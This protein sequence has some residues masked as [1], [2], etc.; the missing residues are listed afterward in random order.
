VERRDLVKGYEFPKNRY[1]L[2]NDEDFDSVKVE[3]SSVM[4]IDKFVDTDSIDPVYYLAPDGEAGRD[5]YAVLRE[6]IAKTGK[7]ALAG[8]VISQREREIAIRQTGDGLMA[9]TLYE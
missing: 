3:T 1:V 5:V 4:T 8:V 6:A 7:T 2:L 9:D